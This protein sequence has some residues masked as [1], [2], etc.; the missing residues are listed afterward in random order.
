MKSRRWEK[1]V[2][3]PVF[4]YQALM[5]EFY[6][7]FRMDFYKSKTHRNQ[8]YVKGLWVEF[9]ANGVQFVLDLPLVENLDDLPVNPKE[10]DQMASDLTGGS[11]PKWPECGYLQPSVLTGFYKAIFK[12]TL[13]NWSPSLQ[14]SSIR[15]E[16]PN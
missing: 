7:N 10:L 12:I 5:Q 16:K 3:N 4:P 2:V 6:A 13:T 8:V 14:N 15:L 1:L 11:V 9:T